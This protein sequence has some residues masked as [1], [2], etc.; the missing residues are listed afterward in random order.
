MKLFHGACSPA[1]TQVILGERAAPFFLRNSLH[2]AF[3]N[4][5]LTPTSA[6]QEFCKELEA[7]AQANGKALPVNL[8]LGQENGTP[9]RLSDLIAKF[10]LAAVEVGPSM[11]GDATE[12]RERAQ[13]VAAAFIDRFLGVQATA[14]NTFVLFTNGRGGLQQVFS[15]AAEKSRASKMALPEYHFTMYG[16]LAKQVG[17]PLDIVTYPQPKGEELCSSTKARLA[18]R[19]AIKITNTPHNPTGWIPGETWMQKLAETLED[20][21][22]NGGDPV[23]HCIDLAV[24]QAFQ[25][26]SESETGPYLKSYLEPVT[27]ADAKTPW[28][29]VVS[30]SKP[31]AMPQP[32]LTFL[33]V[34]PNRAE[35]FAEHLKK[36]ELL[37]GNLSL[38]RIVEELFRND[39][40]TDSL[41]LDHYT[42]LRQ[43][44]ETNFA[45]LKEAFPENV[46]DG[47]PCITALLKFDDVKGRCVELAGKPF[48]IEST[49]DL[50][51]FL[52]CKY[53]V[54]TVDNDPRNE[55]K[56]TLVRV[57][58]APDSKIV[59]EGVDRLKRGINEVYA[60]PFVRSNPGV[61]RRPSYQACLSDPLLS[62]VFTQVSGKSNI[63]LNEQR[64]MPCRKQSR[65]PRNPMPR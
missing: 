61:M 51:K 7:E 23:V 18:E 58:L 9:S 41:H 35:D 55:R 12:A 65:R 57:M 27:R 60:T 5:K 32:G 62:A 47:D 6:A 10:E 36:A 13:A 50:V 49:A 22:G 11:N 26:K 45:C 31:L 14:K 42:A 53:G 17:R 39:A 19:P 63:P 4:K 1:V 24:H 15:Y 37:K 64:R 40:A 43:K 2:V 34:N 46:V 25:Q 56:P 33:I 38:Y 21:N 54:V 28:V 29:V 44:Y 59:R 20:V 30:F 52:G 8:G 48:I 16:D 3:Y